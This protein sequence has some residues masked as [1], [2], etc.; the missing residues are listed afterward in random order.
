MQGAT[1]FGG[2]AGQVATFNVLGTYKRYTTN[3]SDA[4]VLF[5]VA[6]FK[7]NAC[8]RTTSCL[9]SFAQPYRQI[10]IETIEGFI[11]GDYYRLDVR[12]FEWLLIRYS[13]TFVQ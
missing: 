8:K 10:A 4:D 7:C 1:L 5:R 3:N 13:R 6:R 11:T 2:D 9:P 12:H